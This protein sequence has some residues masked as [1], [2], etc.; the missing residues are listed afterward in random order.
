MQFIVK[1]RTEMIHYEI[2]TKDFIGWKPFGVPLQRFDTLSEV[3]KKAKTLREKQKLVRIIKVKTEV[4]N[5]K[6]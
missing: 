5:E 6:D 3:K 2:Q 1:E 4:Y